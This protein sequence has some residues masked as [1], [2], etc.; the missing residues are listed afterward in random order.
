MSSDTARRLLERSAQSGLQLS[1]PL[2]EKLV[3]YY[4]LLQRWNRKINL[5]ALADS[6]QAI[7]RLLLEPVAGASALPQSPRLIDL[8]S[9]G[10][11]PAIPL[12]LALSAPL[13]VMVESRTRKA[14]FLREALRV[15]EL[16]GSVENSRFEDL[17]QQATYRQ[18]MDLVSV[19]AV[20]V[21]A[22]TLD[23]A[24]SFLAANGRIALFESADTEPPRLPPMLSLAGNV[25]LPGDSK[26]TVLGLL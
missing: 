3:T 15:L 5:T 24:A 10:G 11:S 6:D 23:V 17:A 26:L 1:V 13:L 18:A 9:G 20:R 2:A 25:P 22:S 8:G 21:D 19:R 7:D 12:A 16:T 14:A 4:D